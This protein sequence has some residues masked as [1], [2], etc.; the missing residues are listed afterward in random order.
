MDVIKFNNPTHPLKME[1]ASIVNGLNSKLWVERYDIPGEFKFV[2]DAT[3]EMKS[4]LPIGSFVSHLETS[5]IM[6]V[7]NHEIKEVEGK[8]AQIEISGRGFETILGQRAVGSN[9]VFPVSS[10]TTEFTLAAAYIVSQISYLINFH[11]LPANVISPDDALPYIQTYSDLA[12]IPEG[13]DRIVKRGD[14]HERVVELLQAGQLGIKVVRP[15]TWSPV[16]GTVNTVLFIHKGQDRTGTV[17]LSEDTGEITSAEYLWS[18]KQLK[19]AA[20]ISGRWVETTV[21]PFA[22]EINRRWMAIEASDIDNGFE[23]APAGT[24]LANVVATMQQRGREV[25]AAQKSTALTKV[26]VSKEAV[27]LQ[28]RHDFDVG[29]T[30]RVQGSYNETSP[31]RITE[32]VEIEDKTGVSAFPTLEL[33]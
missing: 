11:I 33:I 25:L 14:L 16:A 32:F 17:I 27:R 2:A 15:G 19:N 8:D 18:S 9:K 5:E 13:V 3:L 6:V 12:G 20:L 24:D 31:M 28:Y 22:G 29:D 23:V 7:E 1:Q 30:I 26:E 21:V 10:E 4:Q